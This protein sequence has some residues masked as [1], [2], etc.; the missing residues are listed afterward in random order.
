MDSNIRKQV[1][2]LLRDKLQRIGIQESELGESFD[3]VKSGLL[4]SLEFVDMVASMEKIYLH[5]IDFEQ[6]LDSGEFT[7]LGGL[8]RTFENKK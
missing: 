3:L 2:E 4:N 6:A 8:I 7:T 5:E 1:M